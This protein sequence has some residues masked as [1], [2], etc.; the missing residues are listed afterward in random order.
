[1]S[2]TIR[3]KVA[4]V[5]MSADYEEHS[6]QQIIKRMVND[7]CELYLE[8]EP[9]NSYDPNAVAVYVSPMDDPWG[10]SSY[11][12][13]YLGS[14]LA[15]QV[16]PLLNSGWRVDCT[17][18]ERT[19]GTE[20]KSYGVNIELTLTSP[21]ERKK[22][23]PQ[24]IQADPQPAPVALT[25]KTLIPRKARKITFSRTLIGI[26]LLVSFFFALIKIPSIGIILYAAIFL[27]APAV[28]LLWPLIGTL[29]DRIQDRKI[30]ERN[31]VVR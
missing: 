2:Q 31:E 12:I 30:N 1:M 18:L 6:R 27:A 24:T 25:H 26:I 22:Y 11:Q 29:I 21:E 7:D 9:D 23:Q 15:G 14:E 28:F 17:L 19:G 5:T 13:G 20:G 4:G 3:T 10:E 8:R 16:T